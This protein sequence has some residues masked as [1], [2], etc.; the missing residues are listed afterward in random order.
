MLFAT[1]TLTRLTDGVRT[2]THPQS[3]DSRVMHRR[4]RNILLYRQ[5]IREKVMYKFYLNFGVTVIVTVTLQDVRFI[6]KRDV[7][8]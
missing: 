7:I 1:Q 8:A 6:R 4:V 3:L 5:V 2:I